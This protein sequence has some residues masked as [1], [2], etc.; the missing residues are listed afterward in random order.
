MAPEL[1]EVGREKRTMT[2]DIL[3]ALHAV[4]GKMPEHEAGA[5]RRPVVLPRPR[6]GRYDSSSGL[7][8]CVEVGRYLFGA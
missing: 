7:R 5:T 6:T 3:D 1:I 4:R 8:D 2:V